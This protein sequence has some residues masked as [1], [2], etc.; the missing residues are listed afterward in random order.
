M[1]PKPTLQRAEP[2]VSASGVPSSALPRAPCTPDQPYTLLRTVPR[3]HRSIR[4]K[5]GSQ[6]KKLLARAK[7][8]TAPD[9]TRGRMHREGSDRPRAREFEDVGRSD[10]A[11]PGGMRTHRRTLSDTSQFIDSVRRIARRSMSSVPSPSPHPPSIDSSSG[12][13]AEKSALDP[14]LEL[15]GLHPNPTT[16]TGKSPNRRPLTLI[17]TRSHASSTPRVEEEDER[18]LEAYNSET[19]H[20][21]VPFVSAESQSPTTYRDG[22]GGAPYVSSAGDGGKTLFPDEALGLGVEVADDDLTPGTVSKVHD[23]AIASTNPGLNTNGSLPRS[24]TVN[25][26]PATVASA[27]ASIHTGSPNA[28]TN[29]HPDTAI[30]KPTYVHTQPVHQATGDALEPK[31]PAELVRGTPMI[32]VS[33]KKMKQKFFRLDADQGLVTWESEKTGIIHIENI[34]EIRAGKDARYYRE[35]FKVAL[36][37]EDRWLTIVYTSDNKYKILHV[38]AYSQSTALLWQ[39]TLLSLHEVR[40]NIMSGLVSPARMW[41][42]HYWRGADMSQDDRLEYEE[43]ERLCRRLNVSLRKNDL[44]ERFKSADKGGKGYL[45]F[46]DFQQF[47]KRLQARPEI[48]RLWNKMRGEG[49]FDLAVFERFMREEQKPHWT[50]DDFSAFLLSADNAAFGDTSH[51][52]TR[53]LAE[54]YISSSHNTYLVGHQLVGE[55]TIEGYIRALSCGCRSVEVDIWD[56]DTEPVITHG[57][58]LT[59]SVP[60][61][62]VAQA[63]AKYAFVASPYPVIISAEMH[64][65]IEQQTQVAAIFREAFGDALVTAPIEG[66]VW[67]GPSDVEVLEALPSPEQLKG[68]VLVK[69][70]NALLSEVEVEVDHEDEWNEETGTSDTGSV[71]ELSRGMSIAKR[72]RRSFRGTKRPDMSELYPSAL[73]SPSPYNLDPMSAALGPAAAA[74][75]SSSL[76]VPHSPPTSPPR[77]KQRAYSNISEHHEKPKLK[78]SRSLADLLIYTVG[79]K[80]RGLNKKERY[81]VEQMFSLSEKTANKVTKEN[82]MGLVKH[83]RTNLV[84]LYPNGTRVASTNYDPTRYWAAGVQ[85]V[86]LNWQTI[87]LGNMM[88]QAMF[89][90]NNKFGYLLKPEALRLKECKEKLTRRTEYF[91][92]I[93][94]ISAQQVPRRRDEVGREIIKDEIM[95]PL[96]EVS[97]HTPDWPTAPAQESNP[98]P[99]KNANGSGSG[100]GGK[101]A[102]SSGKKTD[103]SGKKN[104]GKSERRTYRTTAVKNNGFSPVWEESVSIPFTCVGDMWDLAFVKFAV[105]DDDDL[106]NPL[107]VY[108]ASLGSLR[109]GYRHL[110]LYD[111]Q[112]SQYLFSTLFVHISLRRVN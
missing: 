2:L 75:P 79:V 38:I 52:M 37:R 4:D 92:D 57:R 25:G 106:D 68:R 70:K 30:S 45:D 71:K 63:I 59:G 72:M 21:T 112:F 107:A 101:R 62:H 55:S 64:A 98:S 60:L 73:P 5:V 97:L 56:G 39:R 69:F 66:S 19:S 86:A 7:S 44:F 20:I 31:V 26:G 33:E 40:Q 34:K 49:L 90:R 32:K 82:A 85:L 14:P 53:P 43:M 94:V 84:R 27:N 91:L 41:E 105:W 103:S 15:G 16:T 67:T 74:T 95:D 6:L 108:C 65:G 99:G 104:E 87:D 78:M 35:Q 47:V 28:N 48:K 80:F 93:T 1:T 61:R 83:C 50:L 8:F 13:L 22:D 42:R 81:G 36:D 9:A 10:V 109:Q 111:L 54:Y 3:R 24:A 17:Q 11:V 18:A 96:V 110:P 77:K 88:N 100:N 102:D 89:Q 46:S 76:P 12:E 51:D 29:Q 23:F 58:T